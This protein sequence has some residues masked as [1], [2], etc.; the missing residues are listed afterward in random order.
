MKPPAQPADEQYRLDALRSLALLDT[1][2]EADFDAIVALGRALLGV[3]TCLI[4]LVDAERQWF[5]ARVGLES[6]QTPRAVSFCGHAILQRNVFIVHDAA[7]DE[8]FH[9]NPL[10]TGAPHIRFYAGAP[11]ELPS[12]YRIGTVCVLSPDPQPGFGHADEQRLASLARLT[13]NAIAV[14]ALRDELDRLRAEI[15]RYQSISHLS[16]LPFAVTDTAG[17]IRE[18]NDAFAALCRADNLQGIPVTAALGVEAGAWPTP[19][20]GA[21]DAGEGR[22]VTP[23]GAVLRVIRDADGFLLIAA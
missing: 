4:T 5:K 18:C 6:S 22:L 15:D 12:G 19:E 16:A 10:V 11:I 3:P 1:P 13:L 17:R 20:P 21:G 7:Q 2:A 23:N 9:D 8:R 14:R